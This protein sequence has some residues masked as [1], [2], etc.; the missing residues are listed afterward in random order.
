MISKLGDLKSSA[1]A[2]TSMGL[3]NDGNMRGVVEALSKN[4]QDLVQVLCTPQN[5]SIFLQYGPEQNDVKEEDGVNMEDISEVKAEVEVGPLSSLLCDCAATLPLQS[6]TY[7]GLTLGLEEYAPEASEETNNISYKGF[8]K[9]CLVMACLRLAYDLDKTCGVVPL[10]TKESVEGNTNNDSR[11]DNI[12]AFMRAKLMLRYIALLAR[13]GIVHSGEDNDSM[14]SSDNL[15]LLSLGDLLKLLVDAAEKARN[16]TDDS[17]IASISYNNVCILLSALVLSTLPYA[18]QVLSKDFVDS[19]LQKVETII[20][21]YSSPFTPGKGI[22]SLLLEKPQKEDFKISNDDDDEEGDDDDDEEDDDEGEAVCAD[23]F[24]DL[25]RSV[26][27]IVKDYYAGQSQSKFELLSDA[28]WLGLKS[29]QST[30]G[31]MDEDGD[32]D[33]LNFSGEK[34]YIDIPPSC[35]LF[36]LLLGSSESSIGETPVTLLCP[37]TTGIIFG[38]LSIF[39]PPPE[40]DD[41]EFEA[42]NPS[43][44]SYIKNFSL[45]DRFLL[46]EA[47]RDCLICHRSVVSETGVS[48]GSAKDAAEQILAVSELFTIQSDNDT[49]GVECGIVET[50]LSMI[51]QCQGGLE[52][53]STLGHIYLYRV[54]IELAKLQP[55]RIPQ[56]LAFAIS[57]LFEDFIPSLSPIAKE[58]LSKWFS[59]HLTNTDYQWPHSYW[60]AWTPYAINSL[61]GQR[62]SRG[63]FIIKSIENMALFVSDPGSIVSSCLPVQSQLADCVVKKVEDTRNQSSFTAAIE[64]IEKDITERMWKNCEETEDIEKYL[65]GDEVSETISGSMDDIDNS[66]LSEI[67]KMWWRVG[68]VVRSILSPAKEKHHNLFTRIKNKMSIEM[69][70]SEDDDPKSDLVT[71]ITDYIKRY[72]SA[73]KLTLA[74]DREGLEEN[75]DLRGENKGDSMELSLQGQAYVISQT[76]SLTNFFV[77]AFISCLEIF[78]K[79]DIVSAKAVLFWILGSDAADIPVVWWNYASIAVNVGLEDLLSDKVSTE[80]QQEISM[81]IDTGRDDED[82]SGSTPDSRRIQ[83][84]TDFV[85]P[86]I[87]Y[88]GQRVSALIQLHK[89]CDKFLTHI[90]ADLKEGIKYFVRSVNSNVVKVLKN[91]FNVRETNELGGSELCVETSI[92]KLALQENVDQFLQR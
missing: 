41:D 64:T 30:N 11:V 16:T 27:K 51:I 49:T 57:D 13:V 85:S 47:V 3:G 61:E 45:L 80:D 36:R 5:A 19:L 60:N 38:R 40:E 54:L 82:G 31:G 39:D 84:A 22:M 68:L 56:S 87:E 70:D 20:D 73:I 23:T 46:S 74:K 67:D 12:N 65:T 33:V 77:P 34:L 15:S 10:L 58:N 71:D 50:V 78:L 24:Q 81:I 48:R 43:I 63:E 21:G 35:H 44:D 29:K 37:S 90:E 6:P 91:D 59:Y 4:I 72:K 55:E 83:K 62:N 7:A 26:R 25:V 86:L 52:A 89:G 2:A 79:E 42:R 28:P 66:S 53:K 32:V 92:A 75:I 88:A 76:F 1:E 9:R 14:S 69:D 18:M 17:K 8:A